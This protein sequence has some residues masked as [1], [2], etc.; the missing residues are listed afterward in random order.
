MDR[1]FYEVKLKAAE[2]RKGVLNMGLLSGGGHIS[3][4][5][6]CT[7]ILTTLYYGGVL[8][9]DPKNPKWEDR[10][11]F[12]LS[13]SHGCM[14]LFFILAD[15]GYFD[16][17][18]LDLFNRPGGILGSHPD[19]TKT[20]G[21]EA[22]AASLG[23]GFA[24][25][26]GI[27]Y[28]GKYDKKD[29]RVFSLVGDGECQEGTIWESLMFAG[30]YKLD[31][32][33][34]IVDFNGYGAISRLSESSDVEPIADKFDA[35]NFSVRQV[36]GHS[37]TQLLRLLKEVPYKTG[38]P[39][40]IIAH[41]NKGKGVSFMEEAYNSG[42]PIWHTRVPKGAEIEIAKRDLENAIAEA[43]KELEEF[44]PSGAVK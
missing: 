39:S 29:Y 36:D 23:L 28:N 40:A 42:S 7:D 25:A 6:S 38:K 30:A 37:I 35:F 13:K 12:V 5:F 32:L 3:P 44:E 24:V 33:T 41:T 2:V 18:Y 11:R 4:G 27:A 20:P 1:T 8:K 16:K 14:P 43:K 21:I 17:K 10:D 15:R 31:N 19:M 9:H 34:V 26:T 22:S